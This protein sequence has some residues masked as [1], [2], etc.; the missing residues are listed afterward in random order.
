VNKILCGDSFEL[1]KEL[2]AG[3][4]DMVITD[5]PYGTTDLAWDD[6]VDLVKLFAELRRVAKPSAAIIITAQ[7]PFA[8]DVIIAGRD[9]FRHEIIWEK[10]MPVG[11]LNANKMP[12]RS[13]ENV[14]VFGQKIMYDPQMSQAPLGARGGGGGR[15]EHY[16]PHRLLK[17][18]TNGGLHF[19]RSVV[20]FSNGHAGK[21]LH[22]TQ[23]PVSLF[24]YLIRTY[25]NEN[26]VVLD[27]FAGSCTTAIA[28][29]KSGRKYI[30]MEREERYVTIG[31]QRVKDM[32]AELFEMA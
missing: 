14:L 25:S 11:F 10:T 13:H 20:K 6:K 26:D 17:S 22:P 7:Q 4:V 24:E 18:H 3:S 28:A 21:T 31:E 12:L 32:P 2:P 16:T 27:P 30:C 8:T 15:A 23:K 19:P 29:L 9:I 1:L 5:P